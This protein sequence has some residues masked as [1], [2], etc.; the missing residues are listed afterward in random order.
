MDFC[1]DMVTRFAQAQKVSP[2]VIQKDVDDA[3]TW[4]IEILSKGIQDGPIVSAILKDGHWIPIVSFGVHPRES[5]IPAMKGTLSSVR[6]FK[7][8]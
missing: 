1:L 6:C 7:P 2:G 3:Q 8:M 5:Y 4:A